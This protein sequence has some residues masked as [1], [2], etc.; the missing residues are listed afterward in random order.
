[1]EQQEVT[2]EQVFDVTLNQPARL[3][4]IY[5]EHSFEVWLYVLEYADGKRRERFASEFYFQTRKEGNDG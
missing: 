3:I 2:Q 5:R 4:Q 1:M